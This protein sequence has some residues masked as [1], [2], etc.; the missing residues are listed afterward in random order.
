MQSRCDVMVHGKDGE[1]HYCTLPLLC[2][3]VGL[4][5]N[6]H[7]VFSGWGFSFLLGVGFSRLFQ[8]YCPWDC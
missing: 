8:S 3:V 5:L 1:S 6:L 2:N 7:H 4:A